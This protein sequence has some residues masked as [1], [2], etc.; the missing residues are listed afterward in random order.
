MLFD[1]ERQPVPLLHRLLQLLKGRRRR[2][3]VLGLF[4]ALLSI[5]LLFDYAAEHT[6]ESHSLS[7][8]LGSWRHSQ[9]DAAANA[10]QDAPSVNGTS[11]MGAQPSSTTSAAPPLKTKEGPTFHLLIPATEADS[12]FCRTVLSTMLLEYPPPTILGYAHSEES[13]IIEVVH[14]HLQHNQGIKDE[15]LVL[16]V[17]GYRSWFQLPAPVLVQQYEA[18]LADA[19]A[20]LR[21]KYGTVRPLSGHPN[22]RQLFRQTVLWAADE[23][24]WPVLEGDVACTA[25]PQSPFFWDQSPYANASEE[26]SAYNPKFVNSGTVIGP[27][28]DLRA[29]FKALMERSASPYGRQDL[30]HT[31]QTLFSEQEQAREL[32]R[33]YNLGYTGRMLEWWYGLN[34]GERPLR[35][36]NITV[37]P[38][39]NYEFAMGLDYNSTLFQS[40]T[41]PHS[42]N[43]DIDF[44]KS[45]AQVRDTYDS[46]YT[47]VNP[48]TGA[49]TFYTS[50]PG[51][52]DPIPLPDPLREQSS[53]YALPEKD[54]L[55]AGI[56]ANMATGL[57]ITNDLDD[58]PPAA[59]T[60]WSQLP[61]A[62][63]IRA[64]SVPAALHFPSF[65]SISSAARFARGTK[66]NTTSPE[67][68]SGDSGDNLQLRD[69]RD[70]LWS[71]LWFHDTAR[72]LL[73]RYMRQS[74][75]KAYE[76]EQTER[77]TWWRSD[78]R[79]GKG[80]VWTE[81]SGEWLAWGDVCRGF[82]EEVFGDGK[83]VWL[84]EVGNAAAV[85]DLEGGDGDD[86]E[87]GLEVV[88]GEEEGLGEEAIPPAVMDRIGGGA[89]EGEG[90][91]VEGYAA[92]G[93]NEAE[94]GKADG[95]KIEPAVVD[96]DGDLVPGSDGKDGNRS[97]G[98]EG[99]EQDDGVLDFVG[100]VWD[101]IKG[102]E[103]DQVESMDDVLKQIDEEMT[104]RLL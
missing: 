94:E 35:K 7:E 28:K 2:T 65:A 83:G 76:D 79:G 9:P 58:L 92:G 87:G 68:D 17:D 99:E 77:E 21:R 54:A 26:A 82:E 20:R 72:A 12:N 75:V 73:R 47:T 95:R 88:S 29:I 4:L 42:F 3:L 69:P 61:L 48:K 6:E 89:F 66:S 32:I 64:R 31:L 50:N 24:C 39:K 33:R 30:Q 15:D 5:Y 85:V 98:K 90:G 16:I 78:Q 11:A 34:P 41:P 8:Q 10:A 86:D 60:P 70:Q 36:T 14:E 38:G 62:H 46:A 63:N 80:G 1:H 53:P 44:I 57:T 43:G 59:D 81:A 18:A 40:M 37:A 101:E 93:V 96:A 25:V 104:E 97:E 19:N 45:D 55:A 27:A 52:N 74:T 71:S 103:K 49:R 91:R 22:P 56:P 67:S 100:E 13:T 51:H 84:G 23:H 102:A